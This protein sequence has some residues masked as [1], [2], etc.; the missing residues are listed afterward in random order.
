MLRS[1]TSLARPGFALGS[2]ALLLAACAGDSLPTQS[3]APPSAAP[4]DTVLANYLPD[5]WATKANMP[6][7]WPSG[8]VTINGKI[9]VPGGLNADANPTKTLFVYNPG[10]N[11]PG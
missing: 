7:A 8:A 4:V 6:T 2:L 5:S 1:P 10:T 11:T 9:Y 3:D